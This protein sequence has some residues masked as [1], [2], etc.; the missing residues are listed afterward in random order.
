[1]LCFV[2]GADATVLAT[3][4][5]SCMIHAHRPIAGAHIEITA[6]TSQFRIQVESDAAGAFEVNSLPLVNIG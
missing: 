5:V 4:A 6:V 3:C 2:P 1:M